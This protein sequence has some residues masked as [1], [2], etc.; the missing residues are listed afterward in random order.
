MKNSLKS[1]HQ[2]FKF[3]DGIGWLKFNFRTKTWWFYTHD[4]IPYN[5]KQFDINRAIYLI[6][7]TKKI[8]AKVDGIDNENSTEND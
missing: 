7:I 6:Q 4:G 3:D 8:V 1:L 5:T 2:D